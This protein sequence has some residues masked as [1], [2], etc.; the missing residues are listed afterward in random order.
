M[1]EHGS[2]FY[3]CRV[4]Q[5]TLQVLGLLVGFAATAVASELKILDSAGLVRAVKVV[6][7]EAKVVL[8]LQPNGSSVAIRGECIATNIDGLAA[9]QRVGVSAKGEC[10]F[11]GLSRGSWQITVPN[12]VSWKVQIYE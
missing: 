1:A 11:A 5:L 2:F 8:N 3:R 9:E 4:L 12:A 7:N 6:K 10:V